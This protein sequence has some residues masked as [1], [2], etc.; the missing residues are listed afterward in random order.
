MATDSTHRS[1]AVFLLFMLLLGACR[2]SR[3][4]M[5]EVVDTERYD[6]ARAM[7]YMLSDP[8]YA[9]LLLD[10]A[11]LTNN[12]SNVRRQYL[13]AIVMYNGFSHPDSSLLMCRHLVESNEW[14]EV[15][16]TIQLVEVYG[17]MATVAG[18]LNRHADVIHYAQLASVLAH[19]HPDLH[20][21][22]SDLLS[23]VGRTMAFLGQKEEGLQLI[24]RAYKDVG[25][26]K[27]WPTLMTSVNIGRKLAITQSEM[28]QPNEALR[29]LR[30]LL[31]KMEYFRTH[32]QEFE[33]LQPSMQQNEEAIEGYVNYM[34]VRCY[35]YMVNCY[36]MMNMPDSATYWMK[37][38]DKYP[39]LQDHF[40]KFGMIPSL[41]KLHFDDLVRKDV[42][43]L[44]N[45][46]GSDT[47]DLDYVRMLE[48]MSELERNHN[49]WKASNNYL[50]RALAVRDRIEQESFRNQLTDQL[51]IYQLQDE[52]F[53]RMDAEAKSR[54]LLFISS[55][56]GLFLI[57]MVS[58]GVLL[59]IKKNLKTLRQ[60]HDDTKTE[61]KE[62]KQQIEKLS[63]GY[64][65][66]TPEKL[67]NRIMVVM[68]TKQPYTDQNFDIPQ[69]ASL[70]NSN[71]TYISKVINKMSG[72][73]FRSWL[74]QYRINLVQQY[75]KDNPDA[76]LDELCE[77]SGYASR[78]SLFRHFKAITGNTPIGWLNSLE[79]EEGDSK[80]S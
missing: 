53:N 10:S 64:V 45:S 75:L 32:A 79:E 61:L 41:V 30:E 54:R 5:S 48:A 76:S 4:S 11:Y 31:N 22:E 43:K 17:L 62:A 36:A 42:D 38:M 21:D 13:K 28:N 8:P 35:A 71:R 58:V 70:L 40:V 16:D 67:Y 18:T 47:L 23:R 59:R 44:I 12:L 20:L 74:A 60:V 33:D 46:L 52:R 69:L 63:Q 65:T 29:T 15:S 57:L 34:S 50:V 7:T 80:D 66:E 19:G 6:E 26:A 25:D 27:T 77:I 78:S 49:N 3:P 73:N 55:L 39:E 1:L 72:L 14:A 9:M 56:L 68:D 24:M 2:P 37:E 51:T